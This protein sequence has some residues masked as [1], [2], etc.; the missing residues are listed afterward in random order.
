M[1]ILFIPTLYN[2]SHFGMGFLP[3]SGC[4]CYIVFLWFADTFRPF[5]LWHAIFGKRWLIVLS[6]PYQSQSQTHTH[7]HTSHSISN[8]LSLSSSEL[9]IF[10]AKQCTQLCYNTVRNRVARARC[11][12]LGLVVCILCDS[13]GFERIWIEC[14]FQKTVLSK[15]YWIKLII[16]FWGKQPVGGV[17]D[18]LCDIL[19]SLWR[20]RI[21]RTTNSTFFLRI[22]SSESV[23]VAFLRLLLNRNVCCFRNDRQINWYNVW[24]NN[25]KL[26][27]F[28]IVVIQLATKP[29]FKVYSKCIWFIHYK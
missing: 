21:R 7:T 11:K 12:W 18:I 28:G 6:H 25:R 10:S 4:R 16:L 26:F 17:S 23:I 27:V 3:L 20:R 29:N 24:N 9:C 13:M 14:R 15:R 2:V 19:F 22:E 5:S 8:S 1:L